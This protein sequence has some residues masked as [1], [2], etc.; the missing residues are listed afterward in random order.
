MLPQLSLHSA[1]GLHLG[2]HAGTAF[3][4]VLPYIHVLPCYYA[5]LALGI[6]FLPSSQSKFP[7]QGLNTCSPLL[8]HWTML[9]YTHIP[10]PALLFTFGLLACSV[11]SA[12]YSCSG[13]NLQVGGRKYYIRL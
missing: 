2:P 3:T 9:V 8:G 11:V 1:L 6:Q 10:L 12:C 5:P 13:G 4:S 7:A